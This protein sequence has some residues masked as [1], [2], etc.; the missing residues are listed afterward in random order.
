M[1]E[2]KLSAQIIHTLMTYGPRIFYETIDKHSFT[3]GKWK[4][5]SQG[6]LSW[7]QGHTFVTKGKERYKFKFL[8][9]QALHGRANITTLVPSHTEAIWTCP[10]AWHGCASPYTL[11]HHLLTAKLSFWPSISLLIATYCF[12]TLKPL[13]SHKIYVLYGYIKTSFL[14]KT[15]QAK[16]C[17]ILLH[18]NK[19]IFI[20]FLIFLFL[21]FLV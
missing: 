8:A 16:H 5:K 9:T 4:T 6:L 14:C 1:N 11:C 10:E 7:V 13:D 18:I 2:R 17:V 3:K 19:V 21:V 12:V 15:L 20:L